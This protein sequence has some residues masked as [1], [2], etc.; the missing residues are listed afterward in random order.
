MFSLDTNRVILFN[1]ALFRLRWSLW[2]SGYISP[3]GEMSTTV[4]PL[5]V[6]L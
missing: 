5:N 6:S 3:R 4:L 2:Y 1:G